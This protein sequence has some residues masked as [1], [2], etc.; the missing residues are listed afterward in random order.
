VSLGQTLNRLSHHIPVVLFL[1]EILDGFR[2]NGSVMKEV[3][4]SQ[5]NDKENH[6]QYH[7][8]NFKE[9]FHWISITGLK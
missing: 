4:A 6:S 2:F 7:K 9:S 5:N 3:D 1:I 8:E